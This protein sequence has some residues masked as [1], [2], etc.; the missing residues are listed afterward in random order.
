M[1]ATAIDHVN[2]S[3]PADRLEEVLDFYV[4]TLGFET[5]F[6]DPRAAIRSEPGLFPIHLGGGCRLYVNPTDSFDSTEGS[7]RHLALRIDEAPATIE[8][9]LE[10][11]GVRIRNE[12]TREREAFGAYTSYYVDDPFG[13][14]VELMATGD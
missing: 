10:D 2:L 5:D 7:Y 14:T 13:Y 8:K 4:D 3:F 1:D 11:A 12:A 9:R 6:D